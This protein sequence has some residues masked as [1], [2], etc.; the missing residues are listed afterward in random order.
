MLKSVIL[1]F[2]TFFENLEQQKTLG[3]MEEVKIYTED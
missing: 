3:W 2:S 1:N